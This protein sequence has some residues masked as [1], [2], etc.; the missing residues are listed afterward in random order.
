MFEGLK[1]WWFEELKKAR[2]V[3]PEEK[4][5]P[6]Q[7]YKP[8]TEKELSEL[9]QRGVIT[10]DRAQKMLDE[11]SLSGTPFELGGEWYQIVG[12]HHWT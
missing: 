3:K 6:G 2:P 4:S 1:K 10:L 12:S 11:H 5:L 7:V 9:V 8:I